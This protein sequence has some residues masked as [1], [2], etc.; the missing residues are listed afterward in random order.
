MLRPQLRQQLKQN[1]GHLVR[2][3]PVF[4]LLPGGGGIIGG[5]HTRAGTAGYM[6]SNGVWRYAATDE[7]R[8]DYLYGGGLPGYLIERANTNEILHNC[9]L[10]NV[11]W[12]AGN[13]TKGSNVAACPDGTTDMDSIIEDSSAG[14]QH[15][16]EQ[17]VSYASAKLLYCDSFFV[18]PKG[19]TACRIIINK[20]SPSG[21]FFD[22]TG[23]GAV[24][25]TIGGA[26]ANIQRLADTDVYH[27]TIIWG[28]AATGSAAL[29][30]GGATGTSIGDETYDG[31]GTTAIEVWGAQHEAGLF[32]S[33]IKTTTAPVTRGAD[34]VKIDYTAENFPDINTFNVAMDFILLEWVG[35]PYTVG[36]VYETFPVG[37]NVD[38]HL[39]YWTT[40]NL[41][42][43]TADGL[44][45]GVATLF[46]FPSTNYNSR[47]EFN[48]KHLNAWMNLAG[49]V[50][51][52]ANAASAFAGT[53]TNLM[54]NRPDYAVVGSSRFPCSI[55]VLSFS[56]VPELI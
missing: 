52:S 14:V 13:A 47:W 38:A 37:A 26:V 43:Y 22:L 41:N 46:G 21:V 51:G 8:Y 40:T 5:A 24:G 44:G 12:V 28:N 45:A 53:G 32:S 31:A 7:L 25:D 34:A 50:N 9:D 23:A 33:M 36:S 54:V 1:I 17:T 39:V 4:S 55:K 20:G 10:S 16:V 18:R 11:A 42:F 35:Y 56:L 15:Y 30:I 29:R 49:S 27:C 6:D 3:D 19:R 2:K 48:A